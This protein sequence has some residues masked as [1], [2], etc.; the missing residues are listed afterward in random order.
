[1]RCAGAFNSVIVISKGKLHEIPAN[2]MPIGYHPYLMEKQFTTRT[3]QLEEGDRIYLFS[4][5]FIDQ[6][7][8]R[9]NK[10]FMK[11]N[12]KELLLEIQNVPVQ[13]QKVLLENSLNNWKGDLEQLDDI[14]VIGIEV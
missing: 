10:K 2:K 1:M 3:H 14:I 5:G 11:R 12:F 9:N 7:G 6:F 4:D 13:A 8:W